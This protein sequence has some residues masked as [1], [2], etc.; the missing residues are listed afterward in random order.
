VSEEELENDGTMYGGK[1]HK[2]TVKKRVKRRKSIKY[3]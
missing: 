3:Y 2:K 1:K